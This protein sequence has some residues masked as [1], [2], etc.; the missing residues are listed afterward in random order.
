M[1]IHYTKELL[2]QAAK[3]SYSI[4][5]VCRKIGLSPVGGNISTVRKKLEEFE[6][7]YSH[8][9]GQRWNAGRKDEGVKLFSLDLILKKGT[10]YRSHALKVRLINAGIKED[11]CEICGKSGDDVTLELHHIDGDHYNNELSNLQ[12]LCPDCHSKT[13]NFRGRGSKREAPETLKAERQKLKTK[14]C[15]CCGKEFV[16]DRFNSPR[17]FCGL[18]CYYKKLR[19]VGTLNKNA[20]NTKELKSIT[21]ESLQEAIPNFKDITHLA[22]YFGVSRPTIR[23]HLNKYGLLESFKLKYDFNATIVLQCDSNGN[24]IKEWPSIT[25]ASKTLNIDD[26]SIHQCISHKRRSAGGYIWIEKEN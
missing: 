23:K 4:S 26:S 7:D 21:L 11:K 5:E 12:I 25:D 19:E 9:T 6:V 1:R 17:R 13:D 16:T 20:T 3:N 10:N 8:F 15:E 14:V 18:E 22:E 2:E 24:I